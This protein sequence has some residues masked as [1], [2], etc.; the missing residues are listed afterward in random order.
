ML[1]SQNKFLS[2]LNEQNQ[3]P[4]TLHSMKQEFIETDGVSESKFRA[5]FDE[6][7]DFMATL[8]LDGKLIEV[9]Q[10]FLDF[11]GLT[12]VDVAGKYL[13]EQWW[14]PQTQAQLKAAIVQAARG[15]FIR[16]EVELIGNK[17][18]IS[19]DLSLKPV[20]N[21]SKEV[22]LLLVQGRDITEKKTRPS[23]T[24]TSSTSGMYWNASSKYGS[25]PQ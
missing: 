14:E 3:S 6:S 20:W 18:V 11:G 19:I 7:L 5:L 25:R 17:S 8:Q 16:Y 23:A 15:E 12:L 2:T 1:K 13:W 21:K 24:F 9:N 10:T 22:V 4:F